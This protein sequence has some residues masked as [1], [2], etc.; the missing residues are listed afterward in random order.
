[1]L[2]TV[3]NLSAILLVPEATVYRWVEERGLPAFQVNGRL[4]AN[5]VQVL[6][7]ATEKRVP[8][9]SEGISLATNV[10][11]DSAGRRPNIDPGLEEALRRGG[12]HHGLRGDSAREILEWMVARLPSTCQ[13]NREDLMQL[14]LQREA[15]GTTY[16]AEGVAV[17]HPRCPVIDP[18]Q[19]PTLMIATLAQPLAWGP[20][21]ENAEVLCLLLSPNVR[22]HLHLVS[23]LVGAIPQTHFRDLLRKH[24]PLEDVCSCFS[25]AARAPSYAAT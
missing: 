9:R 20:E 10:D 19:P 24:S 17:P 4:R 18:S 7:W 25:P 5:P 2:L 6:E 15:Q 1:M 23:K 3:Q 13:V 8:M 12:V 22:A 16:V 14:L 21:G 11:Y